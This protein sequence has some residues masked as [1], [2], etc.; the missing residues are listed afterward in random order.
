M[1]T[2]P[3]DHR[4]TQ[5]RLAKAEE[6]LDNAELLAGDE[7]RRNAAASLFVDAGIAASDVLCCWALGRHAQ[8]PAHNEAVRLLA[9]VDETAARHL[10][11]L[12]NNKSR[13]SYS[14][15]SL[16][17]SEFRKVERAATTLVEAARRSTAR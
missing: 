4:V 1:R 14:D 3:C 13:I 15:R 9:R 17:V 11:T 8:G 2:K 6:F 10:R 5:G 7:D 16:P 12:L